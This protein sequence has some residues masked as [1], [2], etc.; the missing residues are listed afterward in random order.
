MAIPKHIIDLTALALQDRVLTFKERQTIIVE[1]LKAGVT[2]EEINH[3]IDTAQL[4]SHIEEMVQK[5]G[6]FP[7]VTE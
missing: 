5:Y 7:D 6:E 3:Y 1:A 2:A 4:T